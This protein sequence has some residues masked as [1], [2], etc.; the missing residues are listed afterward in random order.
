[1][2][3]IQGLFGFSGT[4]GG[5]GQYLDAAATEQVA[6]G[7]TTAPE[8][9]GTKVADHLPQT[10]TLLFWVSVAYL[11]VYVFHVVTF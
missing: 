4:A 7:S 2:P 11:A 6:I 9:R 8:L 5:S 10:A 3:D 1:M